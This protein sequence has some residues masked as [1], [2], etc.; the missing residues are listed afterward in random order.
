MSH[1]VVRML[2]SKQNSFFGKNW[3]YDFRTLSEIIEDENIEKFIC[4]KEPFFAR[5]AKKWDDELNS[6]WLVRN[7]HSAKMIMTATV[8]LESLDYSEEK[9]LRIC[10]PYLEYY[11]VFYSMR[12][13]IMMMPFEK[14]D[15][16]KILEMTHSKSINIVCALLRE[17]DK[18]LADKLEKEILELKAFREL[19]SYCAPSSGDLNRHITVDV[20]KSCRLLVEIAQM[21]SEL[22]ENAMWKHNN[23]L[24]KFNLIDD[25]LENAYSSNIDGISF[26]DK[27]DACRINYYKRKYQIP[28]N[29][30][31]MISEGHAE[32]FFEAWCVKDEKKDVFNPDINWQLIFDIP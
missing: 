32:D 19:H 2:L 14:W 23:D 30:K 7:Y 18:N 5:I 28:T 15:N 10:I 20:I 13:L 17:L 12:S 31:H 4:R 29:I 3:F 26:Y 16:G 1:V 6:Q 8:L 25:I 11:A 24:S 22:L 9:N 21:M 27:E